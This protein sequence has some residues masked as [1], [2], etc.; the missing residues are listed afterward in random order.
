M[1]PLKMFWKREFFPEI[2]SCGRAE[3]CPWATAGAA[4]CELFH[5]NI[6]SS[7]LTAVWCDR[8]LFL[9]L[10]KYRVCVFSFFFRWRRR[11]PDTWRGGG[12]WVSPAMA[13]PHSHTLP[14]VSVWR[15]AP[16][17]MNNGPTYCVIF[18]SRHRWPVGSTRGEAQACP[19]RGCQ[20]DRWALCDVHVTG[21][22]GIW[23][24]GCAVVWCYHWKQN[25]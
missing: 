12:W 24:V 14:G 4:W 13:P 10:G 17:D 7:N 25:F 18:A 22:T 21:A 3:V 23:W 19:H 8:G 2:R 9:Q 6:F 20:G 15:R 16:M 5:R 11:A 1:W